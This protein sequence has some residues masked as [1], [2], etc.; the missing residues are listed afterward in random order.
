MSFLL[1]DKEAGMTSN[2]VLKDIKK[3]LNISKAGHCG[4]LDPFATGLMI[5]AINKTTKLLSLL[6][7]SRKSYSGK[8]LFGTETDTLDL[9]GKILSVDKKI[10]INLEDLK[11]VILKKFIGKINQIPPQ[12]SAIKVDGKRAYKLAREGNV[13]ELKPRKKIVY[14]LEILKTNVKNVFKFKVE[15]SSG[16]YIRSLFR[17]IAKS[18]GTV[19][20]LEEL[21]RTKI[22]DFIVEK[23]VKLKDLSEKSL[24]SPALFMNIKKIKVDSNSM[25]SIL[26]GKEIKLNS[27]QEYLFCTSKNS[28]ILLK[29]IKEGTYKIFK[30]LT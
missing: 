3:K 2:D 19:S 26:E 1:I 8:V 6:S 29:K 7:N 23:S 15:V 25:K 9:T 24:L 5:V 16:T 14:D 27:N 18:L 13:V 11:K 21:R 28:L 22:D 10:K 4:T 30:N 20:I 17:D 12:Y